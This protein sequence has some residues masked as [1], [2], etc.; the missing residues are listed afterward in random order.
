[1]AC[2]DAGVTLISPFVG[3]IYDWHKAARKV[4]DIPIAEDPGVASVTR[5]Y[6]YYKKHGYATQVM[7]AS[8]RKMEQIVATGR[9]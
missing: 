9:M 4:D 1:M 6:N 2:A 5:I 3:R 7:G 8:F